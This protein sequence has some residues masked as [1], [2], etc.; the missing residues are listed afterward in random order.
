MC[1]PIYVLCMPTHL[2]YFI[3]RNKN[4]E[5]SENYHRRRRMGSVW[6]AWMNVR[7]GAPMIVWLC[8][9]LARNTS[10]SDAFLTFGNVE[11]VQSVVHCDHEF[12]IFHCFFHSV[13]DSL[14]RTVS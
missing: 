9:M 3:C 14:L 6:Q 8:T 2:L 5:V 4:K 11:P 7:I 10:N 12:D 13:T 1:L